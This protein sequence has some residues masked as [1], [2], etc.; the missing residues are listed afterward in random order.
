M[1]SSSKIFYSKINS[2][3]SEIQETSNPQEKNKLNTSW[4]R[5]YNIEEYALE[6]TNCIIQCTKL[7]AKEKGREF[8]NYVIAALKNELKNTRKKEKSYS[9]NQIPIV[10]CN[11]KDEENYIT[12]FFPLSVNYKKNISDEEKYFIFEELKQSLKILNSAIQKEKENKKLKSAFITKDV[13]TQLDKKNFLEIDL[14][15]IIAL[16]KQFSFLNKKIWQNFFSEKELPTQEMIAAVFGCS[17]S[18]ASK[19]MSRFYERL[20]KTI[21]K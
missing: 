21:L 5:K 17:K 4:N 15:K 1:N 13:L 6:I 16:E 7:F 2:I 20:K 12:D 9:K 3:F 10:S 18:N 14:E 8:S 11:E 19:M